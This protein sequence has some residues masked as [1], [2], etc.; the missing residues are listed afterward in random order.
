MSFTNQTTNLSLPQYIGTDIP[1][2][3]TDV[4]SAYAKIDTAYGEQ[5][6]KIGE[7]TQKSEQAKSLASAAQ[8]QAQA[9]SNEIA[10]VT[11]RV[12]TLET[13]IAGVEDVANTA[14]ETA[15]AA[16]TAAGDAK[17]TADTAVSDAAKAQSTANTALNNANTANVTADNAN[18]AVNNMKNGKNGVVAFLDMSTY[19]AQYPQHIDRKNS[20]GGYPRLHYSVGTT[21]SYGSTCVGTVYST[22]TIYA[23]EQSDIKAV[24]L[25]GSYYYPI[26][27]FKG[28]PLN[29]E[30]PN[31]A[32]MC[33]R[34]EL[35]DSSNNVQ[36][37][38]TV[39]IWYDNEKDCTIFALSNITKAMNR[40]KI[41][42]FNISM[43]V[44]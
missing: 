43:Q 19:F 35:T 3:L 11:N 28:N 37:N 20:S 14:S 32:M 17:T 13:S 12:K 44:G 16:N 6:N 34:C 1:S 7:S 31:L 8:A 15:N 40:L 9:A 29:V 5:N 22:S 10:S 23:A 27:I 41:N 38:Q 39:V 2:I 33:G 18:N 36:S 25:S 21:P 30:E 24:Q 26:F 42:S 4:N